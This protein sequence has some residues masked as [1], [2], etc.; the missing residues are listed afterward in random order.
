MSHS[1]NVI[2]FVITVLF[3]MIIG[4]IINGIS[5]VA[6]IMIIIIIFWD[7]HP[8]NYHAH[9]IDYRDNCDQYCSF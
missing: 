1:A 4:V 3:S 6:V 5:M 9:C 8:S 2:S 7:H